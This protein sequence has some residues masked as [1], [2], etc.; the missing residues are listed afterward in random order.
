MDDD[1]AVMVVWVELPFVGVEI[2]VEVEVRIADVA[3][4][5]LLCAAASSDDTDAATIESEVQLDKLV[6]MTLL[7]S[8][9]SASHTSWLRL[10]YVA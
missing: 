10:L 8:A 4:L 1:A 7:P 3:K 5:P 6:T 9:T 2:G